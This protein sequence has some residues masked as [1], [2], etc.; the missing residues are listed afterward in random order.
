MEVLFNDFQRA[1]E[2]GS[3]TLLAATISP[4]SPPHFLNRLEMIRDSTNHA[5]AEIAIGHGLTKSM[6]GPIKFPSQEINIWTEIYVAYWKSTGEILLA[7]EQPNDQADWGKCY[8]YW[9]DL[10]NVVI[11]GYSSGVLEAWTLPVLYMAGKH[12]RIF[13]IKADESGRK[14]ANG[15]DMNL[16]GM[17]DDIASNY[18]KNVNLEDAARVINRMFTLCISDRYV[19]NQAE[20]LLSK[21]FLC[22]QSIDI[23]SFLQSPVGRVTQMGPLLHNQPALQ[24]VLQIELNQPLQKHPAC[25]LSLQSRHT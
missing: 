3:G 1:N 2:E 13:A 7:Q 19:V 22:V 25:P 4:I 17:S 10:S 24:N 6:P 16:G 21:K 9:K 12:L 11:R 14:S 23:D 5:S 15:V 18:G 8:E 20:D